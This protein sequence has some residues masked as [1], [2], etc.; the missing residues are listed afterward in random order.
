V[1]AEIGFNPLEPNEVYQ[2]FFIFGA[3]S[4]FAIATKVCD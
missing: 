3:A 1:E 2:S 4:V